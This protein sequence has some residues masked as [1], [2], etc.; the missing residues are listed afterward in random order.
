MRIFFSIFAVAFFFY[1]NASYAADGFGR[2]RCGSDIPKAVIGQTMP[3]DRVVAIEARHEVLSL[4]DLGALEISGSLTLISWNIC[5][6]EYAL[7]EKKNVIRDV[8]PLPRHSKD[9]PEFIGSCQIKATESSDSIIAIL[10]NEK[11]AERLT[12]TAAWK[13]DAKRAKFVMLRTEGLSCPRNGLIT[14]DGGL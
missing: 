9:W 7:L 5:G 11:G 1:G 14:A 2:I 8:L 10:K 13:I 3:N 6:N 12:A 4:K